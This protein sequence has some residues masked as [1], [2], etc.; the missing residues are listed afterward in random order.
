MIARPVAAALL[1]VLGGCKA[2]DIPRSP[3]PWITLGASNDVVTSMDTSRIGVEPSTRVVWLR[4]T[5]G[6]RARAADS[7]LR[8][9][10]TE[11]RHRLNCG[12]QVVTDLEGPGVT[13]GTARPF[14]E[15][16]YGK[17]VFATVC[18]A[19]SNLPARKG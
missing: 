17:R 8:I 18:D 16:P 12:T 1:L 14:K 2:R 5:R 11:T 15:H 7:T 3:A 19:F 13:P 4:Q 9:Q 6:A 10:Q